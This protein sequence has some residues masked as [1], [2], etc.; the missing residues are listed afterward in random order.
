MSLEREDLIRKARDIILKKKLNV[1]QTELLCRKIKKDGGLEP[2][3]EKDLPHDANL[4]YIAENIRSRFQTKVKLRGTGVRGRIEISYFD[5][6]DLE[7][8]LNLMGLGSL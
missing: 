6:D 3:S 8:I 4:S 5:N 1:R 2:G 7:R